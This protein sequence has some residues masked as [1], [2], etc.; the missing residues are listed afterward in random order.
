M[1]VIEPKAESNSHW[2]H[3]RRRKYPIPRGRRDPAYDTRDGTSHMQNECED[4][5]CLEI[6]PPSEQDL[7]AKVLP[8]RLRSERGN[9]SIAV[10]AKEASGRG[11]PPEHEWR[12]VRKTSS[13]SLLRRAALRFAPEV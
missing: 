8:L 3:S 2:R 4:R 7:Q 10:E 13:H 6:T 1:D 5:C 9:L 12:R 11:F